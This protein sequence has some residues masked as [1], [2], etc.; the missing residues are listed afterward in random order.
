MRSYT[1]IARSG[2]LKLTTGLASF[3]PRPVR[4]SFGEPCSLFKGEPGEMSSAPGVL[5][6]LLRD[7]ALARVAGLHIQLGGVHHV[8]A[9]AAVLAADE[10]PEGHI[11]SRHVGVPCDFDPQHAVLS[12]LHQGPSK[13]K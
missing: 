5:E 9:A 6:A 4:G 2:R 12:T 10:R 7:A 3:I 11:A 1:S 13:V 8:K